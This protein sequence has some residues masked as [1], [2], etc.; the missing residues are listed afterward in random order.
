[1]EFDW[2]FVDD[3]TGICIS[4]TYTGCGVVVVIGILLVI[5]TDL[6]VD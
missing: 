2:L 4:L 3:I 5:H 1:M 6:V